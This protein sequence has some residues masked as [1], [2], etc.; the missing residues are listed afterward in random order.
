MSCELMYS[1]DDVGSS[2]VESGLDGSS[3]CEGRGIGRQIGLGTWDLR[4][5]LLAEGTVGDV[6]GVLIESLA[7]GG[8]R[9]HGWHRESL[10]SRAKRERKVM[11][12]RDLSPWL[13]LTRL[14]TKEVAYVPVP[15]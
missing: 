12:K 10:E 4:E 2:K 13:C 14:L 11:V 6:E 9:G 1:R 8:M 3:Q 5:R 7:C 15:W